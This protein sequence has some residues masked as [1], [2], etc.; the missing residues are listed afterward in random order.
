MHEI[1][2]AKRLYNEAQEMAFRFG[3]DRINY[4]KIK[5][6]VASGVDKDM[7][8]YSLIEHAFPETIAEDAEVEIVLEPLI[9]RCVRCQK[10]IATIDAMGGCPI[11]GSKDLDIVGGIKA[12]VEGIS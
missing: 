8:R 6:G 10:D 7:L 11:C 1:A 5:L 12:I 3:L 9:A 4:V 2:L